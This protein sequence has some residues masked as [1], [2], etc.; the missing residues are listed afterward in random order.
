LT[1]DWN[2]DKKDTLAVRRGNTYYFKNSIAGGYSDKVISYGKSTDNVIVGDWDG[3]STDTLGVRRAPVTYSGI[4]SNI[5]NSK[6]AT[7][8]NQI[9]GVVAQGSYATVYL[10]E[11]KD[12]AW[13]TILSAKGRVGKN[14]IGK[15][16]EGDGKTP[17]GSYTLGFAFGTG[18][19]P[20][21]KVAYK[22][23]TEKSYWISNVNDSEYNTWQERSSSSKKDEHLIKYP[24]Q[25]K[26]AM[27]INYNASRIK[28]KGS[29]I[30]L[31]CN[32]TGYT[33]GCVSVPQSTM[34]TLLKTISNKAYIMIGNSA[35]E[36]Q[37]Y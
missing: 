23:I 24:V 5:A 27:V 26:Y 9:I 34:L 28:N 11:K 10:F 30:F 32:G 25:Y 31:H 29:A 8:T 14:G 36:L 4:L 16:T 35:G 33:A 13:S 7:K 15:S 3:N 18:T 12:G 21:T 1:G 2:G 6:T 22:Q 37:S 17:R 19:N 20:G